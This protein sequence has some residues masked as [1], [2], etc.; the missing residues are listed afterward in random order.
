MS[1]YHCRYE[2]NELRTQLD[3]ITEICGINLVLGS[4]REE[5]LWGKKREFMNA[6]PY[7]KSI[8]WTFSIY[9]PKVKYIDIY[10]LSMMVINFRYL[11]RRVVCLSFLKFYWGLSYLTMFETYLDLRHKILSVME[12][13]FA[14]E[15]YHF[16]LK[17][18][19]MLIK[20]PAIL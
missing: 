14:F 5:T 17:K 7:L 2:L 9:I 12:K 8:F 3:I 16:W 10:G 13:S 4:V 20:F 15:S 6:I 19:H 18:M 1:H 11:S